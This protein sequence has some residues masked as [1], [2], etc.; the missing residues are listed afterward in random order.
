MRPSLT[1]QR[2]IRHL[3]LV[4]TVIV[5]GCEPPSQSPQEATEAHLKRSI[6]YENQGQYKAA[7]IE[8]RN[9]IQVDPEKEVGHIQLAKLLMAIGSSRAAISVLE[10][11]VQKNTNP[12]LQL[13][14]AKAYCDSGKFRSAKTTLD[15]Y[16]KKGGDTNS[17]EF[18]VLYAKSIAATGQQ[19]QAVEMLQKF[20]QSNTQASDAKKVLAQLF[21]VAGQL[22]QTNELVQELLKE[23]KDDPETMY[24]AAQLAYL[25]NDLDSAE[26]H[27]SN[28]LIVL[29][30]SDLIKP[31]RAKVLTQLSN[32]L[33]EQGRTTEALIYA[34]LLASENPDAQDAKNK[35]RE[36]LA[37]LREND[38]D[39][40]EKLL[41]E[42]NSSYPNYDPGAVYLGI[43]RY[44]KGDFENADA[45]F[46]G[47]IDPETASPMAISANALNKLRLHQVGEALSTLEAALKSHPDNESLLTI[48]GQ[49]AVK[50]PDK[51]KGGILALEKAI[52]IN[53]ENLQARIPLALSYLDNNKR[54]LG[55]AQLEHSIKL[56]PADVTAV[57]S[58]AKV[59][60][61]TGQ[62]NKAKSAIDTMLAKTPDNPLALNL[63]A[64][65]AM[66]EDAPDQAQK[67]YEKCL[68]IA[69]DNVEAKLGLASIALKAKD[70]GKAMSLYE[71]IVAAEPEMADG[72]KGLI[73]AYELKG[74]P[75]EGLSK[76]EHLAGL[77]QDNPTP[78]YVLAEYYLRNNDYK[79]A[80]DYFTR[81]HSMETV[82]NTHSPLGANIYFA[83]ASS[84]LASSDLLSAR[85]NLLLAARYAPDNSQILGTLAEL[86]IRANRPAEAKKMIDEIAAAFPGSAQSELL[87]GK[88]AEQQGDNAAALASYR[89]G[90]KKQPS[91]LAG[92]LIYQSL[93]RNQKAGERTQFLKEWLATFPK[94]SPA[95]L[96]KAIAL[97]EAG[98]T[99][100][101][102]DTYQQLLAENPGNTTILNNLAWLY[103]TRGDQRAVETAQQAYLSSPDNYAVMDTYGWILFKSGDTK[104]AVRLLEKANRKAPDNQE[105]ASHLEEARKSL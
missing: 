32:V 59:M 39:A 26:R 103:H 94:S 77:N 7:I 66:Q 5:S 3:L 81:G 78:A 53:P 65:F 52:A 63:S 43:V 24:L 38:L 74:S 42:L 33:T 12:E 48:Y 102:M 88:L 44:Q 54:E 20:I 14:L 83:L 22:D 30:N 16:G 79:L 56:A 58:Y 64:R 1:F 49:I 104:K 36:A 90:W 23:N 51:Q 37:K 89:R 82:E 4:T 40:A 31:M 45:L 96:N 19:K 69:P 68:Q 57:G 18:T 73:S 71:K 10:P 17:S 29:P 75:A 60:V 25:R 11:I 28:A 55:I 27:L 34:K 47:S 87:S 98:D 13:L 46:S 105:I 92:Q 70:L 8:A 72:Y 85:K 101:A 6:A 2:H 91:D 15:D 95:R 21:F 80:A 61:E 97:Q 62:P 93:A 84:E 86:E 76:I 67:L 100:A 35:L 99:E 41:N 50:Q 9:I